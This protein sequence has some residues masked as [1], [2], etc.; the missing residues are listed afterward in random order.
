MATILVA[1]TAA[2]MYFERSGNPAPGRRGR[3]P[4]ADRTAGGNME[5]KE[6]RFGPLYSGNFAAKP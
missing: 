3:R 4:A 2:I 5:G 6:V 1:F